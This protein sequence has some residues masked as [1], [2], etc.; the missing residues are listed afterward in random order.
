M[1]PAQRLLLAAK[2]CDIDDLE[3]LAAVGQVVG[4]IS[5]FIHALQKER[6]A[7]S[8]YLASGGARF[9]DARLERLEECRAQEE[10]MRQRLDGLAN[11]GGRGPAS[12]RLLRRIAGA[13]QA[14][15]RLEAVREEIA[16]LKT[17]SDQATRHFNRLIGSLLSVVFDAA[18]TAS[19]PEIT[20]ALVAIFHFMQGKEL[21]GQE[22]ACGSAGFTAGNLDTSH[23]RLLRHLIEA[24]GRCFDTFL[25]FASSD[26][27]ERWESGMP[28]RTLAGIHHLREIACRDTPLPESAT[29]LGE[30]WYELTTRRIDAMQRVEAHLAAELATLCREKIAAAR[31]ALTKPAHPGKEWTASGEDTD[32]CRQLVELLD[33]DHAHELGE[34]TAGLV[35]SPLNRSLIELMRAQAG[36]LQGLSDELENTRKALRE[37]KLVERAKGVIMASRQMTEQQAYAFMRKTAMDQSKS[38]ADLAGTI[39]ELSDILTPPTQSSA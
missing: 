6:G 32:A 17:G 14:L 19:D 10:A 12:A 20:R 31:R 30:T 36:H 23:R 15:D 37:R 24:Q 26:A 8:I 39:L 28:G 21:A 38:M 11:P 34:L 13:L 2:R 16:A 29:A 22:R 1:T 3:H 25:E 4:D 7:T 18:D 27:R 35:A 9:A 33:D 5:R